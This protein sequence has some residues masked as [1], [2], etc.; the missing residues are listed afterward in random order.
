MTGL[1]SVRLLGRANRAL[2]TH[3]IAAFPEALT[4]VLVR[5]AP[6]RSA[7]A[8]T[9]FS[10]DVPGVGEGGRPRCEPVAYRLRVL[11]PGGGSTVAAIRPP[12]SVC[13][14]GRL[15]FRAYGR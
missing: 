13:E 12:T 14:H 9:R 5:L 4:A 1:P 11:A 15:Q 2:P 6:G 8:T 3:V 10:P 7:Q